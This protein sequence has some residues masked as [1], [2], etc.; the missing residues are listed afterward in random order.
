MKYV[1]HELKMKIIL[2]NFIPNKIETLDVSFDQQDSLSDV[3]FKNF[4]SYVRKIARIR[5]GRYIIKSLDINANILPILGEVVVIERIKQHIDIIVHINNDDINLRV[6]FDTTVKQIYYHLEEKYKSVNKYMYLYDSMHYPLAD[7]KVV[8][9]INGKIIAELSDDQLALN[10]QIFVHTL[11]GRTI[12]L[13][14][15]TFTTIY[16]VKQLIQ[17]QDGSP[18]E[19]QRLIFAGKQLDNNQTLGHYNIQKLCT[20]HRVLNL[21]G[22]G[23]EFVDISSDK[24]PVIKAWSYTAPE[25]RKA[26]KGLCLEGKCLNISCCSFE[27][28]NVIINKGFTAWKLGQIEHCPICKSV[29]RPETCAFNN[30]EWRFFGLKDNNRFNSEWKSVGNS[31]HRFE[32]SIHGT[33]SWQDLVIETRDVNSLESS[34]CESFEVISIEQS[35]PTC[36]KQTDDWEVINDFHVCKSCKDTVISDISFI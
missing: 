20:L 7:C 3:L 11:V 22:G 6:P 23:S 2:T 9:T 4:P 10:M 19:A 36:Y 33:S 27:K 8:N 17:D 15:N 24:E 5:C 34:L 30:C 28:S 13:N 14:V 35:C 1:Y 29:V 26:A 25:W 32:P 21:R 18:P 16:R 12:T 31:Y